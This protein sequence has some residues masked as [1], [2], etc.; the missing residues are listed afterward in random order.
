[1]VDTN[2]KLMK[3]TWSHRRVCV[4]D[5]RYLMRNI[6]T[7]PAHMTAIYIQHRVTYT[8]HKHDHAIFTH[9]SV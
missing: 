6:Q 9:Q 3:S 8:D 4:S 5:Q 7:L 2:E 1:M